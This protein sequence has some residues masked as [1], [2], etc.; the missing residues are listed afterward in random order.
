MV[1][2]AKRQGHERREDEK[3][4]GN[5]VESADRTRVGWWGRCRDSRALRE[6]R[7]RRPP[8]RG[9]WRARRRRVHENRRPVDETRGSGTGGC[10][11]RATRGQWHA[12]RRLRGDGRSK[13]HWGPYA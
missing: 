11:P 3:N 7:R 1:A 12:R 10:V 8:L 9:K 5:D 6:A 13:E 4:C 2:E